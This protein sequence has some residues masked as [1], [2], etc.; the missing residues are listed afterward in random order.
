MGLFLTLKKVFSKWNREDNY[1]REEF[2]NWRMLEVVLTKFLDTE[3]QLLLLLFSYQ[4]VS[5][6]LRSQGLQHARLPSLSPRACSD[7]CPLNQWYH[8]TI[9]SSVTPFSPCPQ[10]F[11]E[12]G[13]FPTSQLFI[14]GGQSIGASGS[15][16][17][18]AMHIQGWFPL[19]LTGLTTLQSK[20]QIFRNST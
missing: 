12:S 18:L 10:S 3:L 6:S 14:S 17:V 16:S 11:S 7:S 4:V 15:G 20:G 9:L 8:P 5:G 2:G 1:V 13:S 19:G